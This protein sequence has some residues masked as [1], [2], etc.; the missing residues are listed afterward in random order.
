[1][2]RTTRFS[3]KELQSG[4]VITCSTRKQQLTLFAI[5]MQMK[6]AKA[7]QYIFLFLNTIEVMSQWLSACMGDKSL[8]NVDMKGTYIT[9]L[10]P[11]PMPA[12]YL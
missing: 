10:P 6:I 4:S 5:I 12:E 1:M 9:I 7:F 3:W 11:L 2:P 8:D